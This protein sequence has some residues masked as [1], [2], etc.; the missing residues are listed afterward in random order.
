MQ[1]SVVGLLVCAAILAVAYYCRGSLIIGLMA[2]LAFGSTALMTLTSLGGS[3][4]LI[5]TFFAATLVTAVAVRRRI[6]RDIGAVFGSIRPI[7][8]LGGVMLYAVVGAWLFPRLFAGQTTVFVQSKARKGVIEASLGPVSA[9]LSQTGYFVLGCLTAVAICVLLLH[10]DRL[11]QIRRGFLLWCSLHAGMGLIDFLGKLS[12][13][14]D[15]LGPIRTASYAMLTEASEAGFSRIAGAYSE[16]SAFGGVSL[17]CLA[18]CY[19]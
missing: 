7:W 19:T 18:F 4:P 14:G 5:Y 17:A 11:D 12:G 9:N 2:S 15:V 6:W 10:H 1:V 8:V 3:S 16:A 13:A